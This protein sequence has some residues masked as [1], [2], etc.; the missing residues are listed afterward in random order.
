MSRPPDASPVAVT[1]PE[2]IRLAGPAA[3]SG[4]G[5]V[6]REG[7]LQGGTVGRLRG[8]GMEY[9]ESRPYQPG[10]D[11][12]S[13]DWRVTAR[14]GRAY[15][16]L[17]REEREHPVLLS[18]DLRPAMFFATRGV[19]KA[20]LAARAAALLAWAAVQ[21]GERVGVQLLTA[22]GVTSRRPGRGRRAALGLCRAL[23][24]APGF[25][26]A[27]TP[28]AVTPAAREPHAPA[29]GGP[30]LT[31][32]L[33]ELA[34]VTRPGARVV[35]IGDFH[36]LDETATRRLGDL[37]RH[38]EVLALL[39]HDRL[40]AELPPPGRYRVLHDGGEAV[41]ETASAQAI[42]AQREAFGARLARLERI[43]SLPT[44]TAMVCDTRQDVVSL[45]Q[46]MSSGRADAAGLPLRAAAMGAG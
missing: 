34:A 18:V 33:A 17:F 3:A 19:F 36:D 4:L 40:E 35:L 21:A 24:G 41:L 15:T 31:A 25:A 1:L 5:R 37:A 10:D 22:D 44:A 2:L 23:A 45:L 11:P 46:R 32:A 14:T 26:A 29:P 28:G 20:V 12:R 27:A 43:A 13:I 30:T 8:R 16:K 42:T 39:I 38:A 7:Q 9:A 6:R